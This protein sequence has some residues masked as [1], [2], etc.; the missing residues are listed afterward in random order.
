MVGALTGLGNRLL[1]H[2]RLPTWENSNPHIWGFENYSGRTRIYSTLHPT[3]NRN[4][5]PF[6]TL[7]IVLSLRAIQNTSQSWRLESESLRMM[8][9]RSPDALISHRLRRQTERIAMPPPR[10]LHRRLI[11]A[12]R[13]FCTG[14]RD[15]L[16]AR[17]ASRRRPRTPSPARTGLTSRYALAIRERQAVVRYASPLNVTD[18]FDIGSCPLQRERVRTIATFAHASDC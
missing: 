7:N 5:N 2:S 1:R 14:T 18:K 12:N 4:I 10:R 15:C 17:R 3:S 13:Q 8:P 6:H 16:K 9:S 11:R